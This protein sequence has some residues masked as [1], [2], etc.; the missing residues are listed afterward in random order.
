MIT[1]Q[2]R[3]PMIAT[4]NVNRMWYSFAAL[5]NYWQVWNG[6][7]T[8]SIILTVRSNWRELI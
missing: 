4:A 3:G 5:I 1:Y 7:R 8:L 2:L 6:L